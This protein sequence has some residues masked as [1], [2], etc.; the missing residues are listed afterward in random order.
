MET[1][2]K[3]VPLNT[4]EIGDEFLHQNTMFKLVYNEH[5]IMVGL[6]K[7]KFKFNGGQSQQ[8]LTFSDTEKV[9]IKTEYTNG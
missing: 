6:S 8:A 1:Y 4:L 2:Y 9:L 3:Q 7:E 5:A